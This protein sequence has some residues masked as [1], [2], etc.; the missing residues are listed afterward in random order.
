MAQ[1]RQIDEIISDIGKRLIGEPCL[2]LDVRIGL[3]LIKAS[4]IDE[5]NVQFFRTICDDG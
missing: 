1:D 2:R 3:A 4:L 5:V